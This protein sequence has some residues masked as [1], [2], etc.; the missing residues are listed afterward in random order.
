MR[1]LTEGNGRL[2]GAKEH[3]EKAKRS[4]RED[5]GEGRWEALER[6]AL[7]E[8]ARGDRDWGSWQGNEELGGR[9]AWGMGRR[10]EDWSGARPKGE[11]KHRLGRP[12]HTHGP[13]LG[14]GEAT[15]GVLCAPCP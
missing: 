13:S 7:G 1:T 4:R 5:A 11:G 2:D 6:G 14:K 10:G 3:P 15:G 12:N 9:L 8:G